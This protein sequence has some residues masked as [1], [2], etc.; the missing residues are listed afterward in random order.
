MTHDLLAGD[1][2]IRALSVAVVGLIGLAAAAVAQSHD[3]PQL[4]FSIGG[5]MVAGSGE[6]WSLPAQGVAVVGGTGIDTMGLA[7]RLR[8]GP[9]ATLSATYLRSRH[10]GF[11][12]ELGYFGV[13]TEQRC[14]PPVN[15]YQ[16]DAESKNLQACSRGNGLHVQ[17][18]MVG[19]QIGLGYRFAANAR[20]TPYARAST[21]IGFLANSFIRTDG[22]ITATSA[23]A[24]SGGVCQWPLIDGETTTERAIIATLAAGASVA[25]STGYRFRFEVRDLIASLPVPSAPA[26]PANGLAPVGSS[27]RHIPVFEAG[28]DVVLERR[29]GR[30]Y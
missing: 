13:A 16:P 4:V 23:C 24:T 1:S 9:V 30:R 20:L 3:E 11:T 2:V 8:P 7:R 14:T 5:G 21:G 19:F 17:T 29:R 22:A 26:N 15:G 10:L 25:I 28:L 18:S 27:L 6:L 12:A